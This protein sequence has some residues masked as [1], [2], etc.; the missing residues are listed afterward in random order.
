MI[1]TNP[2]E[3]V[4]KMLERDSASWIRSNDDDVH[5]MLFSDKYDPEELSEAASIA[6]DHLEEEADR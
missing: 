1:P 4:R 3:F 2:A 6:I 5:V